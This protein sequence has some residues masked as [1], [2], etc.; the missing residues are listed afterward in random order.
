M[1][2][3]KLVS[4]ERIFIVG[5]AAVVAFA[6]LFAVFMLRTR[7]EQG[8]IDRA[9]A[10]A[11]TQ[12]ELSHDLTQAAFLL[13]DGVS[14]TAGTDVDDL[15][16]ELERG[17]LTLR[18]GDSVIGFDGVDDPSISMAFDRAGDV[19]SELALDAHLLQQGAQPTA[20]VTTVVAG[21]ETYQAEISRV[22]DRLSQISSQSAVRS[23]Q[24]QLAATALLFVLVIALLALMAHRQE[25]SLLAVKRAPDQR[26]IDQLTGLV[27]RAYFREQLT[28]ALDATGDGAGYTAVLVIGASVRL[29][30]QRELSPRT[31]DR[32]TQEIARRLRATVR[33][34]DLVAKVERNVFAVMMEATPRVDD[35]ARVAIKLRTAVEA[36]IQLGSLLVQV[37]LTVGIALAPVD[38]ESADE[39]L[40][41]AT[42]AQRAAIEGDDY[43][44]YSADLRPET[45]SRLQIVSHLREAIDTGDQL[46]LAYQPK[47]RLDDSSVVGYEALVRWDHPTLGALGPAQFVPIAEESDLI[48]DLGSWVIDEVCRQQAEW[49]DVHGATVPVSIN[50]SARQFRQGDLDD[51]VGV[52]LDKHGIPAEIIEIEL[53][54]GV[55]LDDTRAPIDNMERLRDLGVRIAVDDFGTGYS[56]LSYLKR[57]PID[58]L[59]IDRSFIR[60]LSAG[61]QDAAIST[62]IIAL[63]HSLQL[64]V[65]AEGVETGEQY[66]VLQALGCDTAQGY[67]FARPMAADVVEHGR[68]RLVAVH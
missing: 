66:G 6:S 56:S 42:L 38:A 65:V 16:R 3:A 28:A 64:E 40:M 11:R 57:F 5:I 54:E 23:Q 47:V 45:G 52:S 34:T 8:S 22:V 36:P 30:V 48:L 4:T 17:H 46:W 15:A 31:R 13:T 68:P 35:A 14:A 1:R 21:A 41:R 53:T 19:L 55:L 7:A 12:V 39:L 32:A 10:A 9:I 29:G 50:V 58:I 59:K 63:A 25:L 51:V 33:S 2:R 43:R 49:L 24:F 37:D 60:E 26:D 61:N 62:A 27:R 44:Y 20:T 18:Y 67:F